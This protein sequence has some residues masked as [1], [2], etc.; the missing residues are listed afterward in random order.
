MSVCQYAA[1]LELPVHG[2]KEN[3]MPV[4]PKEKQVTIT[5]F[6][7]TTPRYIQSPRT[8]SPD[9]SQPVINVFDRIM[10][11]HVL[12]GLKHEN[13]VILTCLVLYVVE[14]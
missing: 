1:Y 13:S 8:R 2:D 10:H 12:S 4:P 9:G 11:E 7:A 3:A 5:S 6:A 14:K